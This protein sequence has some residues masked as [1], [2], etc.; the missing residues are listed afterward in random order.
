MDVLVLSCYW[1]KER[2][3][4]RGK[5]GGEKPR[6]HGATVHPVIQYRGSKLVLQL[7]LFILVLFYKYSVTRFS[8]LNCWIPQSRL[9]SL[10][11]YQMILE[12]SKIMTAL[13]TLN[14]ADCWHWQRWIRQMTGLDNAESG[15][16]L[17][18]TTLNQANCWP[19]QSWFRL[20][21]GLDR[22]KSCYFFNDD[23]FFILTFAICLKITK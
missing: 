8:G 16:C 12:S 5:N 6:G 13:T 3:K 2:K 7:C 19:G 17:A 10:F 18:R 22:A 1:G 11:T 4:A 9:V 15:R 23:I 21:A 14:Q 20:F